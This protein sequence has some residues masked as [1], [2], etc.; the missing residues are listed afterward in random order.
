MGASHSIESVGSNL[1][2]LSK[3]L[4]SEYVYEEGAA[5]M[6]DI[7]Y[8]QPESYVQNLPQ[9][10]SQNPYFSQ[11]Q[12]IFCRHNFDM[13]CLI[14]KE[15]CPTLQ[16]FE[17]QLE[18]CVIALNYYRNQSRGARKFDTQIAAYERNIMQYEADIRDHIWSCFPQIEGM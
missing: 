15:K 8:M 7:P 2:E 17:T 6:K 4:L 18:N 1:P 10:P 11:E 3:P 9:T 12:K 14:Y 13:S 5:D 16:G